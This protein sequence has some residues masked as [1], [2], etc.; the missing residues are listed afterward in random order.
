MNYAIIYDLTMLV[1]QLLRNVFTS[2]VCHEAMFGHFPYGFTILVEIST[3]LAENAPTF[4]ARA[5]AKF[6]GYLPVIGHQA[7]PRP[8]PQ[9][10]AASQ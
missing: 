4:R 6:G 9:A 2:I 5:G 10:Q 7:E 3:D 1:R 8:E